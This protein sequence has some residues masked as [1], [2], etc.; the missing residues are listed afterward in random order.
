MKI[1]G[2][3][4]IYGLLPNVCNSLITSNALNNEIVIINFTIQSGY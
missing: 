4:P 1:N 3:I 2:K